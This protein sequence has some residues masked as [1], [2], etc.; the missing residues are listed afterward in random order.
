MPE[1]A[2]YSE[3]T[4][5]PYPEGSIVTTS[6]E[7]WASVTYHDRVCKNGR[8][9]PEQTHCGIPV[10]GYY[11]DKLRVNANRRVEV[12]EKFSTPRSAN[13]GKDSSA[14]DL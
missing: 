10:E 13:S 12:D 5:Y 14:L 3:P 1:E 8:W 11:I 2:E 9:T 4:D 7:H 6:C